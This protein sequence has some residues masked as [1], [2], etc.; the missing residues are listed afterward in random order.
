[1]NKVKKAAP[2]LEARDLKYS[3]AGN[4]FAVASTE[5]VYIMSPTQTHFNPYQLDQNVTPHQLSALLSEGHFSKALLIALQLNH[6]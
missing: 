5:G 4:F 3:M 6:P 2:R 1:M